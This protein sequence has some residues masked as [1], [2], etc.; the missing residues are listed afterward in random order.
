MLE[1]V[2][3]KLIGLIQAAS[4]NGAAYAGARAGIHDDSADLLSDSA[5]WVQ[6]VGTAVSPVAT[7]QASNQ[8]AADAQA[9]ASFQGPLTAQEQSTAIQD[10]G[11]QAAATT[12]EWAMIGV[13][14]T[15]GVSLILGVISALAGGE[16]AQSQQMDELIAEYDYM[17]ALLETTYWDDL[18]GPNGNAARLWSNVDQD[19]DEVKNEGTTGEHVKMDQPDYFDHVNEYVRQFT[20]GMGWQ[21]YWQAPAPESGFGPPQSPNPDPLVTLSYSLW[22]GDWPAPARVSPGSADVMDPATALPFLVLGLNAWFSL[23]AL[24][25]IINPASETMTLADYVQTYVGDLTGYL[26][27]IYQSYAQAVVG[28]VPGDQSA[29][30]WGIVKAVPPAAADLEWFAQDP[31]WLTGSDAPWTGV[32]GVVATYPAY[33]AHL[34]W[35]NY[36]YWPGSF[37]EPDVLQVCAPSYFISRIDTRTHGIEQSG[38]SLYWIVPYLRNK[39]VLG[40][41]ARWK[42]IYLISRYDSVWQT[43]R[44]MQAMLQPDPP[45]APEALYLPDGTKADGNWSVREL[46]TVLTMGPVHHDPPRTPPAKRYSGP[47]LNIGGGFTVQRNGA[48]GYS[49]DRLLQFLHLLSGSVAGPPPQPAARPMSFRALLVEADDVN[50][51]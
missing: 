49:V 31:P 46:C 6:I 1:D 48:T 26:N 42:A 50:R 9:A 41:M 44:A 35:P 47:F 45:I 40:S 29:P 39:V 30:S 13:T 16:S 3:Q 33:A 27:T 32:Y 28:T 12:V 19:L 18:I 43:I 4:S 7:Q 11:V 36:P 20:H 23:N 25:M 37:L 51:E 8:I 21:S 17:I 14:I 38:S 24:G 5:S 10:A 15:F 22:S 2:T 34:T